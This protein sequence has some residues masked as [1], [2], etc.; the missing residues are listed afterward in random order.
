MAKVSHARFHLEA[1]V[2]D[3]VAVPKRMSDALRHWND[4]DILWI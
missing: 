1:D 2:D 3:G 4:E